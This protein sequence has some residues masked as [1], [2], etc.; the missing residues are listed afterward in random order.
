MRIL[1]EQR[2][3][4]SDDVFRDDHRAMKQRRLPVFG[5]IAIRS[6]FQPRQ[7]TVGIDGRDGMPGCQ[8][9]PGKTYTAVAKSGPRPKIYSIGLAQ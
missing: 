8:V 5:A 1:P 4:R 7:N 3:D 2:M 9:Q 6:K